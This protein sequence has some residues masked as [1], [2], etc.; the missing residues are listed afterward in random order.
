VANWIGAR[1]FSFN[2]NGRRV[3]PI[4]FIWLRMGE[5]SLAQS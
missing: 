4:H 2:V 3:H 5:Q 1:H